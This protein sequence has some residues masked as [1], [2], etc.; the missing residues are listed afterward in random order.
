MGKSIKRL[1][2]FPKFLA[3]IIYY[4][5]PSKNIFQDIRKVTKESMIFYFLTQLF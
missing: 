2:Q 4:G 1:M 3:W 5:G